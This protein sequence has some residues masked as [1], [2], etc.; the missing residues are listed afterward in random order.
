MTTTWPTF[1][2]IVR[3]A[4]YV[5]AHSRGADVPSGLLAFAAGSGARVVGTFDVARLCARDAFRFRAFLHSLRGRANAFTYGITNDGAVSSAAGGEPS[6]Y[7]DG[8]RFTDTATFTDT[9]V[10]LTGTSAP[11]ASAA[12][13]G[14]SEIVIA[15]YVNVEIAPGH[16][17]YVGAFGSGQ[18]CR[19]VSVTGGV[20][21]IRPRLRA[22]ADVSTPVHLTNIEAHLRLSGETPQV[23]IVP[24]GYSE[25]VT[26]PVEEAY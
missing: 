4:L 3:R 13:A 8:T 20:I 19:V 24:G 12:D 17:V 6:I 21:G 1:A 15:E 14:A 2:K 25:G 23:P 18:L 26:V 16:F 7:T 9:T 22:A 11:L 10:A 5:Q